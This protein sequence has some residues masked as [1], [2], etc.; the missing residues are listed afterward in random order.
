MSE[1]NL[2]EIKEDFDKI[3][4]KYRDIAGIL[5]GVFEDK[6][7]IKNIGYARI[8]YRIKTWESFA[9]KI[10]RKNYENPFQDTPD[11][12]GFRIILRNSVDLNKVV[13][14]VE[15]EFD[16]KESENKNV[17]LKPDQFG[18]RSHHIVFSIKESWKSAPEYRNVEDLKF[19]LQIRSELMNAWANI[20][21][22]IFYK[23]EYLSSD[24]KRRLYRLSALMEIGDSE[25]SHLM[26]ENSKTEVK[27]ERM[28]E[29]E[30]VLNKYLPDRK[31]SPNNPLLLL[32]E[33]MDNYDF[34]LELLIKYLETK[35]K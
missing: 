15:K 8:V 16:I 4:A 7:G 13:Q 23:R 25:I 3:E 34:S 20:S 21:H 26:A 1:T 22:Q 27:P 30:R 18:Y 33:E 35:K 11:I 31:R 2:H 28:K 32:L 5:L 19:E 6:I 14:V 12:C 10:R 29:L 9:E 24:I 17:E